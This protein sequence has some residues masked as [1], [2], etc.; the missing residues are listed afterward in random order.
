LGGL[1]E[2]AC[3]APRNRRHVD[4]CTGQQLLQDVLTESDV[5]MATAKSAHLPAWTTNARRSIA[6]NLFKKPITA[7][8]CSTMVLLY[9]ERIYIALC[10][11]TFQ[12]SLEFECA[13]P[14]SIANVHSNT[15]AEHTLLLDITFI[16]LSL[17]RPFLPCYLSPFSLYGRLRGR[18]PSP[19]LQSA[20]VSK[21]PTSMLT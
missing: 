11:P 20:E 1:F 10:Y 18:K 9:Y 3:S 8:A 5:A 6:N 14:A 15:F 2:H 17:C 16:I 19:H 4:S 7:P 12:T 13:R 21:I